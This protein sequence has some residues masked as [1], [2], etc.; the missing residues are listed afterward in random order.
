[1]I[2]VL[3]V[4]LYVVGIET[5][6][7]YFINPELP[8]P[9]TVCALAACLATRSIY[10]VL[11]H[12]NNER[13]W[14]VCYV[15]IA[16]VITA[17][18]ARGEY[19]G[20]SIR[21][22]SQLIYSLWLALGFYCALS[23]L[24]RATIS[25]MALGIL[26]FIAIFAVLEKNPE[27]SAISDRFRALMDTGGTMG[28]V[29]DSDLRDIATHGTIR[30]KVFALEPSHAAITFFYVS[31]VFIWAAR[32]GLVANLAWLGACAFALWGIRSPIL[33][34]C[35]FV[36]LI[37]I[38]V[39]RRQQ[40]TAILKE[41]QLANGLMAIG[42]FFAMA[43]V[44]WDLFAERANEIVEGEGSFMQRVSGPWIFLREYLPKHPLVGTGVVGD[45]D[46]LSD[47]LLGLYRSLGASWMGPEFVGK[48][49]SNCLG[50][51]F[52]YFGALGGL[53]T[54]GLLL[55]ATWLNNRAFW[56]VLCVQLLCVWM[57]MGGYNSARVWCASAAIL[58]MARRL[59]ITSARRDDSTSFSSLKR[60]ESP[61]PTR[62]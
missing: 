29:Y 57:S 6:Y 49:I 27:V 43:F 58:C 4:F 60:A 33:V 32:A 8:I 44:S 14:L 48:T 35:A 52:I 10:D 20:K 22:A 30:A 36:G 46:L 56:C 9:F 21:G 26:W 15:A 47:Q 61:A 45:L 2:N 31:M 59:A 53:V 25:R 23:K 50:L 18:T 12:W 19:Y 51:H 38:V 13:W 16:L 39:I 62:P 7:T 40:R 42:V 3:T 28:G 11:K 1:M 54:L 5:T 55:K 17:A 41:V 34:P 24:P 37:T